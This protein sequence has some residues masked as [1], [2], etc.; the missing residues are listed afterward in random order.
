MAKL[1]A[2]VAN[3]RANGIGYRNEMP[4][5]IPEDL[6]HFKELTEGEIVVMGGNT[7]RSIG[8]PL[9]NRQNW[10]ISKRLATAPDVF[11]PDWK[12]NSVTAF[13]SISELLRYIANH[14]ALGDIF[15]IGGESIYSQLLPYCTEVYQT[16]LETY[17]TTD[18]RFPEFVGWGAWSYE[19][20][21]EF[22]IAPNRPFEVN[23]IKHVRDLDKERSETQKHY[24]E[25]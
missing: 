18:A 23:V 5:Y 20:I 10:V 14:P 19:R 7:A 12:S 13:G 9:P 17:F 15:V 16:M 25:G 24:N 11:G 6:K 8:K 3:D 1:I 21:K 4:W 2:V 22:P